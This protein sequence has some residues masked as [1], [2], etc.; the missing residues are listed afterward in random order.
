MAEKEVTE[1]EH[2]LRE[3]G[4]NV[5]NE[6]GAKSTEMLVNNGGHELKILKKI[7]DLYQRRINEVVSVEG[8]LEVIILDFSL[9]FLNSNGLHCTN[10]QQDPKDQIMAVKLENKILRDWNERSQE[11][12]QQLCMEMSEAESLLGE[13]YEQMMKS[14][15]KI[16]PMVEIEQE[17]LLQEI[18][19]L[20]ASSENIG[21]SKHI[22]NHQ[23]I[24]GDLSKKLEEV[25]E[26]RDALQD[27]NLKLSKVINSIQEGDSLVTTRTQRL[28]QENQ[29][30]RARIAELESLSKRSSLSLLDKIDFNTS[31]S[32][33]GEGYSVRTAS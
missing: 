29:E 17:K 31:D 30:L 6:H 26:Q 23:V 8:D 12:I 21:D 24:P 15:E 1:V 9:F 20:K 25:T 22:T 18:Q 19:A 11:T 7:N 27:E 28:E 32:G 10:I 3:V 4:E 14:M 13:K 5:D 2:G 33:M 16:P